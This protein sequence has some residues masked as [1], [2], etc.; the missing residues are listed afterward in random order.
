ME[1]KSKNE[2][3]SLFEKYHVIIKTDDMQNE[4]MIDVIE[5]LETD[6]VAYERPDAYILRG[7]FIYAIEHFCVS[8]YAKK[9][10]SDLSKEAEGAKICRDKM[11][12]DRDFNLFPSRSNLERSF[13]ENLD[14]HSKSFS[15]YKK[16]IMAIDKAK[17]HDYRLIILI[18][19]ITES[20][21]VKSREVNIINPLNLSTMFDIL[22]EYQNSVW[23]IA[24]LYG[25]E[26]DKFLTGYT[27]EE[28]DERKKNGK[29]L[30]AE[31][32]VPFETERKVHVSKNNSKDDRN[33]V[34]IKLYDC[35]CNRDGIK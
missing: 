4:D 27:V 24:C 1:T 25:N 10:N 8:Q 2:I 22:S 15:T 21:L 7:K 31:N 34:T 6:A 13:R 5:H 26:R 29:L 9:K 33:S 35:F 17:N 20:W 3:Q 11:K 19:D 30:C 12:T 23:G 28:L 16:N 14:K 32:Y 18:E